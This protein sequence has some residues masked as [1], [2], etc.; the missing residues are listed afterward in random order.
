MKWFVQSFTFFTKGSHPPKSVQQ[1][2]QVLTKVDS[3]SYHFNHLAFYL[4]V[5]WPRVPFHLLTWSLLAFHLVTWSLLAF[6]LVTWSLMGGH[7]VTRST[8]SFSLLPLACLSHAPQ[9]QVAVSLLNDYH[10][11]ALFPVSKHFRQPAQSSVSLVPN[12]SLAQ[13][14]FPR[15]TIFKGLLPQIHRNRLQHMLCTIA[16]S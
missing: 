7:L 8:S 12:I 3:L 15:F 14:P 13:S 6:H 2:S 1:L 9:P 10:R 11:G 4:L 5:T 16:N